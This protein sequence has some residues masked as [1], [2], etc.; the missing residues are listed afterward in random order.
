MAANYR[1]DINTGP[2]AVPYTEKIHHTVIVEGDK[3]YS[4][5][6]VTVHRFTL[7]DVDDPDLYAAQPLY[8]WRA[9]DMGKWVMSKAVETPEWHRFLD[10][11]TY[12]YQYAIV[13][14]MKD[15]DYT[16]WQ[17]KWGGPVDV[18]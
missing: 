15:V 5:K 2:I 11:T 6:K 4:L 10:S 17:L 7:S 13:A 16:F 18:R 8:E 3:V 1:R 14:K 12:G 9:S